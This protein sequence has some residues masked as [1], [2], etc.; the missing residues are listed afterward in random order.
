MESEQI[1]TA[2]SIISQEQ[3]EGAKVV[4]AQQTE[5]S[6]EQQIKDIKK[7]VEN[8]LISDKIPSGNKD[9]SNDKEHKNIKIKNNI[10]EKKKPT[11]SHKEKEKAVKELAKQIQEAKTLMIV[12]IKGLPSP[13][14]QSIKKELREHAQI[15]VAKK[16]ILKRII[17]ELGK[18]SALGLEKELKENCA[19][20]ISDL[21][22]F[23]LARILA[24]EKTP[25]YAKAGQ[26]APED[27]E[28][29]AGPT[30]LLPGP[31]ISELGSLG[32]QVAV[33]EGKISIK[34]PKIVV[35]KGQEISSNA[36][37]L[38][39][40]LDIKP[41]NIGLEPIAVYDIKKEKI[42][43]NIKID[44]EEAIKNLKAC[45]GKALGFAQKIIYYCKDTIG[46][47]LAKANANKNA[48]EKLA[49]EEKPVEEIEEKKE[50]I[51]EKTTEPISFQEQNDEN[52]KSSSDKEPESEKETTNVTESSSEKPITDI[53]NKNKTEN[54]SKRANENE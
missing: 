19:F 49:P 10:K 16:N 6:S 39:Q 1:Q 51:E 21:D 37:S 8:K 22:G 2:K 54:K 4:E 12:D 46:Y 26:E 20:A 15:K 52:E 41:F 24:K 3:S 36:A 43:T 32:L 28:V 35:N 50:E 44:S 29:K 9:S 40:K 27:I 23:E 30:N 25:V 13:Q 11:K 47:L 38:F 34:T 31:A 48:L 18:E 7:P 53:E 42:Y 17:K 14:F 5:T 33:E 45:A